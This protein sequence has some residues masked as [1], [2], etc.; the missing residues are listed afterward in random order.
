MSV[1][2][3]SGP[4]SDDRAL[5]N[6]EQDPYIRQLIS[7][8][9]RW[10][11]SCTP[12]SPL[13]EA[14]GETAADIQAETLNALHRLH[15]ANAALNAAQADLQRYKRSD[16]PYLYALARD[17]DY[18]TAVAESREARRVQKARQWC[19]LAGAAIARGTIGGHLYRQTTEL[20]ITDR[21]RETPLSTFELELVRETPIDVAAEFELEGH[22]REVGE[23]LTHAWAANSAYD[24]GNRTDFESHDAA[25]A[26]LIGSG[27]DGA[28]ELTL[29]R[30]G[31]D[32]AGKEH[33][34]PDRRLLGLG[35][36]ALDEA[37]ILAIAE[38][39]ETQSAAN[40]RA[41]Q[42]ATELATA[43]C[44]TSQADN[45]EIAEEEAITLRSQQEI[46]YRE[47][48]SQLRL[49][50]AE[51]INELQQINPRFVEYT[52]AGAGP[53][54]F[55]IASV[56]SNLGLDLSSKAWE[57]FLEAERITAELAEQLNK[58]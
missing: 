14:I 48:L 49:T 35:Y 43:D 52:L 7:A 20:G 34:S 53:D 17:T 40:W 32:E 46:G 24:A 27:T 13:P 18:D 26:A 50:Y 11:D 30:L 31:K 28:I 56:Q 12:D 55:S 3:L 16:M 42:E 21:K 37:T 36:A 45:A 51:R 54:G 22:T 33:T 38:T 47:S 58:L 15:E 2:I 25:A 8:H 4:T 1:E 5:N 10:A 23:G 19:D 57:A 41:F 6:D 39:L 29:R 9:S 44:H